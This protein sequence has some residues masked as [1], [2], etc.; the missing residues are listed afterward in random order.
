MMASVS[1]AFITLT[2]TR[3]VGVA[4]ASSIPTLDAVGII[5]FLISF[6]FVALYRLT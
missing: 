5:V 6:V 1:S 4:A 3:P 2:F